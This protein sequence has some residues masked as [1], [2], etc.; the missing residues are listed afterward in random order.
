MFAEPDRAGTDDDGFANELS[1]L[2][3]QGACVL[4][5]GSVRPSQR[6]DACR[7]LLGQGSEKARRRVLISTTGDFRQLS[8]LAGAID[9]ETLSFINYDVQARSTATNS[10]TPGESITSTTEV[11][12]LADLGMAISNA[13]ESFE[14]D[15]DGLEPAEVRVGV[16]SLLP[17][18]EEYGRQ[19]IFKFLHLINGLTRDVSGM[20]HYHL[21]VEP[22]ARIVPVLSP[23]FDVVVELRERNG[24][25]QE[26]WMIG[27]GAHSSG[28]LSVNPK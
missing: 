27:D 24:D 12:A 20:A 6:R 5:I 8:N 4:V 17:L 26:R 22:S 7:R 21:P 13:I 23:L 18:L 16:D 2:K 9:S 15:A 1:R 11:D 25:T 19:R 3:R 10:S 14:R 28:W